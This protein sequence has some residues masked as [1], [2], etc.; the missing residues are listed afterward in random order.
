[1]PRKDEAPMTEIFLEE[2]DDRAGTVDADITHLAEQR[3]MHTVLRYQM[4][5][6]RHSASA[7]SCA[8]E[9]STA[10][11]PVAPPLSL[12]AN[13]P[14]EWPLA[15]LSVQ[16]RHIG[17]MLRVTLFRRVAELNFRGVEF[18][19]LPREVMTSIIH[20]F[21]N[22]AGELARRLASLFHFLKSDPSANKQADE[23]G[24]TLYA[25]PKYWLYGLLSFCAKACEAK[26]EE[27]N[28]RPVQKAKEEGGVPDLEATGKTLALMQTVVMSF[29]RNQRLGTPD[30]PIHHLHVY[31]PV[32]LVHKLIA[33]M[34]TD[35][36]FTEA[37]QEKGNYKHN[38]E[39]EANSPYIVVGTKEL[40]LIHI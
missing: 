32:Q 14:Q 30:L 21:N 31:F 15:R 18:R 26:I 12:Y 34:R 10:L 9:E 36:H 25:E 38:K 5:A 33:R 40:S 20:D 28:G 29:G 23:L 2:T 35:L 4:Q 17:V 24:L 8:F 13:L 19:R 16:L 27:A 11:A 7:D 6:L 37:T 39:S 1:M 22:I 3:A